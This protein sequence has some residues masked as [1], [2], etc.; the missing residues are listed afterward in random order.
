MSLSW[1]V[2]S[3]QQILH[4]LVPSMQPPRGP[5]GYADLN[6]R[7][8]QVPFLGSPDSAGWGW[9]RSSLG[10]YCS[11]LTLCGFEEVPGTLWAPK[12]PQRGNDAILCS[13]DLGWDD[14]TA[15]RGWLPSTEAEACNK[16]LG[17]LRPPSPRQTALEDP[18]PEDWMSLNANSPFPFR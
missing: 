6:L 14:K 7:L 8:S 5:E 17:P 9:D 10:T 1:L 12:W 16:G 2:P 4:S 13:I 11:P 18:E 3:H 15:K